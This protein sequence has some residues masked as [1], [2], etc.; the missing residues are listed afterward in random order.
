MKLGLALPPAVLATGTATSTFT[1][2]QLLTVDGT[3]G[4]VRPA[5]LPEGLSA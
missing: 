5:D 1:D 2:G 3:D 4:L